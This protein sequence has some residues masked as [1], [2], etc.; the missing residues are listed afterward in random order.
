M[1]SSILA[2]SGVVTRQRGQ[3]IVIAGQEKIGKTTLASGAPNAFMVR[4]EQGDVVTA[5]RI[6]E[7]PLLTSWEHVEQ[8]C[9]ELLMAAQT[10]TSPVADWAPAPGSTIIWDTAT[11]LESFIHEYVIRTDKDWKPGNPAGVNM[12]IA[13][14]G[15]GK[16]YQLANEYFWRWTRYVDDLAIKGG[17][18]SIITCHVFASLVRDPSSGE[19]H[20]WDL[21]LHSPKNDKTYGKREYLMQWADMVGFLHEPLLVSKGEKGAMSM[22]VSLNQGRTLEIDRTPA[23]VAGNRYG[24]TGGVQ[25]PLA[26]GWNALANAIWNAT[27][28][29]IDLWNRD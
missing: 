22:G 17:V 9:N 21:Q 24:M 12:E 2:A 6:P 4:L 23:W 19:Y 15:Y 1:A 25:I 10:R 13:H 20:S 11:K 28:Q 29:Q 18:N 14:G 7:T 8:L 26:N 5:K 27:G 16:A 3:R